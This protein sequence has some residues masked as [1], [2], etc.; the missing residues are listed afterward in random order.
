MNPKT[1]TEI[2]AEIA[3]LQSLKPA[4]RWAKR[5]ERMIAAQIAFLE[6]K[7]DVTADE[8]GERDEDEKDA[9]DTAARW[10]NGIGDTSPTADW[11]ENP[12]FFTR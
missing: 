6:G 5:G 9:V 2:Q 7:V 4:G 3:S 10:M 8:F 12:H 11:S 1:T